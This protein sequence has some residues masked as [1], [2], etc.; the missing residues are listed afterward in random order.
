MI[1][2]DLNLVPASFKANNKVYAS[3]KDAYLYATRDIQPDVYFGAE[4]PLLNA[5]ICESFEEW[6][7]LIN[8]MKL[9]K[10]L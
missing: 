10:L 7:N 3:V 2:V 4:K 9:E 1:F 6:L 8:Q 5:H